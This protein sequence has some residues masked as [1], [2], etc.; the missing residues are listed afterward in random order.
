MLKQASSFELASRYYA[1][2]RTETLP[3]S[4]I[5]ITRCKATQA[6]CICLPMH[7]AHKMGRLH[8]RPYSSVGR[9][10]VH[11]LCYGENAMESIQDDGVI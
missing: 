10:V 1:G 11:E 8:T 3:C 9:P 5:V 7:Q 4:Y 2:T 6:K